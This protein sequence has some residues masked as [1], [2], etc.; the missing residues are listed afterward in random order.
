[1][2]AAVILRMRMVMAMV[3]TSTCSDDVDSA[4]G[5]WR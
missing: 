3:L 1:M 2:V 4:A 5:R